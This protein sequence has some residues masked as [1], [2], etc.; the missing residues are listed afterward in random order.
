MSRQ[1][2]SIAGRVDVTSLLLR[3]RRVVVRVYLPADY[4]WTDRTYPV[5]YMFDGHNLFDRTTSTY[6]KEW[7]VDETMQSMHAEG[8]YSPAIVVGIDAP[9]GRYDRFAMYSAGS[10]DYRT[11]P[12]GRRLKRIEGYAEQTAAFLLGDVKDLVEARYRVARDREQVGVAGS[13]MGGYMSLYVAAHNPDLVSKVMAFSPVV[14]DFPMHGHVLREALVESG[15][16]PA[17]RVYLDMGDRERLD[18]AGPDDLVD[19]LQEL[20]ATLAEA[21]HRQ[22]L[23]RVVAGDRHDERAWARRFPA[24]YLWAFHGVPLD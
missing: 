6:D 9:P 8:R 1:R 7:R 2:S 20:S 15:S 23:A 18:F 16:D 13:S 17:L 21:G 3:D 11:S 19:H 10:W 5:I 12:R 24:A 4:E 22:V 14:L